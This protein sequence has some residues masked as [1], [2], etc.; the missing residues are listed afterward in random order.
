MPAR[1]TY[2]DLVVRAL[3]HDGWTIT[4]DPLRLTYGQRD[5]TVQVVKI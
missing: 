3:E 5:V 4:A 2:H 1:D